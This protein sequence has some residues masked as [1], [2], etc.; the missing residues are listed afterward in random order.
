MK[1]LE[2][3]III[4]PKLKEEEIIEEIN[5]YEAIIKSIGELE[6]TDDLGIRRLA[7]NVKDNETGYYIVFYFKSEKEKT[8][9]LEKEYKN[10]NNI[11][12]SII[13]ENNY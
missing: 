7:Y 9:E 6:K 12:Q 11:L 10:D 5:K 2:S 3:V 13:I 4:N 8:I 1:K